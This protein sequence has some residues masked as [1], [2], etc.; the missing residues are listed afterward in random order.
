MPQ[1]IGL[2]EAT[3]EIYVR[4]VAILQR[5]LSFRAKP[6]ENLESRSER[7]LKRLEQP[8]GSLRFRMILQSLKLQ[9]DLLEEETAIQ[10]VSR[11]LQVRIIELAPQ[12]VTAREMAEMMLS[13]VPIG[14]LFFGIVCQAHKSGSRFVR[15]DFPT[16]DDDRNRA[17]ILSDIGWVDAVN[18]P[19]NVGNALRGFAYRID[20]VGYEIAKNYIRFRGSIPATVEFH[21]LDSAT[22]DLDIQ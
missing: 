10:P 20:G 22:L 13:D 7:L 5:I 17:R 1:D 3:S 6:F 12:F 19:Q 21:W 14:V 16:K 8:N 11:A 2:R 4:N 9:F 15:F 18:M